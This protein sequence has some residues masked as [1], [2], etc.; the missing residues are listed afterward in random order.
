MVEMVT[1]EVDL[2]VAKILISW[3]TVET[4]KVGQLA[5]GLILEPIMQIFEIPGA[6]IV[7]TKW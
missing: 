3:A 1:P 2:V 6:L 7:S 4:P 5:V